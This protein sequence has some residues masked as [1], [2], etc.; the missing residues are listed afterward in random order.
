MCFKNEGTLINGGNLGNKKSVIVKTLQSTQKGY[1]WTPS[2][3]DGM[4]SGD[5]I[6]PS[7]TTRNMQNKH[8]HD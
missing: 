6:S 7:I 5:I 2:G 1:K 4:K 8:I 3:W